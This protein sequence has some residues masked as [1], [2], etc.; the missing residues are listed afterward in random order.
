MDNIVKIDAYRRIT[1]EE[2]QKMLISGQ[3]EY[4]AVFGTDPKEGERETVSLTRALDRINYR[5]ASR[6]LIQNKNGI[7][8][9]GDTAFEV[10]RAAAEYLKYA[11][12]QRQYGEAEKRQDE[13]YRKL[14]GLTPAE[15]NELLLKNLE[16]KQKCGAGFQE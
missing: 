11:Y 2:V 10:R 4:Y 7:R 8:N 6:G 16:K 14:I 13:Q 3:K 5:L 15:H 9:S 12:L 1:E